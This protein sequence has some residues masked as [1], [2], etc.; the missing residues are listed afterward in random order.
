[1]RG[2]RMDILNNIFT[3][4]KNIIIDWRIG[5]VSFSGF[6]AGF[7]V[8]KDIRLLIGICISFV[9][10]IVDII[11]K[12]LKT[13]LK[14]LKGYKINKRLLNPKSQQKF[15]KNCSS[16]E[17]QIIKNLYNSYPEGVLLA[18]DN[19][20]ICKLKEQL[21]ITE[22]NPYGI[23]KPVDTE[24][25]MSYDKPYFIYG[26]QTWIYDAIENEIIKLED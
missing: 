11:D 2:E 15:Y 19:I 18:A 23:F 7:I 25:G 14:I 5:A 13:W 6:I 26:L 21:A 4:I 20:S 12:N 3:L 10:I 17:K 9:I 8:T 22:L 16:E 24:Y 1:M